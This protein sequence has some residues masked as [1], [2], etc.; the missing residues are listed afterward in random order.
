MPSKSQA[1]QRTSILFRPQGAGHDPLN[2]VEAPGTAPGSVTPNK[3]GVYRHSRPKPAV[4]NIGSEMPTAKDFPTT[5]VRGLG[6]FGSIPR[7]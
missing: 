3:Q 2:L 6:G 4:M 5:Q 7:D 1:F